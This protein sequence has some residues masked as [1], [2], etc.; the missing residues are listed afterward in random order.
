M[1]P[2]RRADAHPAFRRTQRS[3]PAPA[4]RALKKS[5]TIPVQERNAVGCVF[6]GRSG[7]YLGELLT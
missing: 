2:E 4:L 1:E 5:N 7:F 3:A 6:A